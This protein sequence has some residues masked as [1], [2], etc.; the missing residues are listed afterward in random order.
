MNVLRTA[1]ALAAALFISACTIESDT[2]M[3][4]PTAAG[5]PIPGFPLNKSFELEAFEAGKQ[6]YKAFATLTPEQDGQGVRYIVHFND[7]TPNRLVVHARK[8][9]ENNYLVRFAQTIEG[10][11]PSLSESGLGFVSVR[12]SDYYMMTSM[13][14]DGQLES[15]FGRDALPR[16]AGT[17]TVKL[18]TLA[19]AE[20]ISAW[21][22]EHSSELAENKDYTKFRVAKPAL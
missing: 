5:D 14:D 11:R 6:S 1:L 20:K 16:G 4:D 10:M 15:I 12:G 7:G 8:M 17:S 21:F 9:S 22:A 3:P 18:D 19:Q 2:V 13:S